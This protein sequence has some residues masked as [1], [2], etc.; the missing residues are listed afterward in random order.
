MLQLVCSSVQKIVQ[1]VQMADK[2]RKHF[3]NFGL[4]LPT[5]MVV[6]YGCRRHLRSALPNIVK[7]GIA[8]AVVAGAVCV[9]KSYLDV[10][11]AADDAIEFLCSEHDDR[12]AEECLTDVPLD[13]STLQSGTIPVDVGFIAEWNAGVGLA[14][15]SDDSVTNEVVAGATTDEGV[16]ASS[17]DDTP[18]EDGPAKVINATKPLEARHSRAL[19]GYGN[20]MTYSRRVFDA[21]KAKF[22][23]PKNTEA[24]FKSVWRFAATMMKDHG[25][26]P[27]HQ[28][29]IL[30]LIVTKVFVPTLEELTAQKQVGVYKKM[31]EGKFDEQLSTWERWTK[32][33]RRLFQLE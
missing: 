19:L 33:C 16:G 6:G 32:K 23:T 17:H 24:N 21:C 20:K 31:I 12:L 3:D 25:L 28:A 2:A 29:E 18:K 8:V 4:S 22:G 10:T 26:R 15:G 7:G 30:P 13:S 27:S 5:A 9:A 11:P 1:T 14:S